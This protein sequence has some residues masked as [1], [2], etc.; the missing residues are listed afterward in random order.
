MIDSTTKEL[1]L[2]HSFTNSFQRT[3]NGVARL[4]LNSLGVLFTKPRLE[5][6]KNSLDTTRR[7]SIR[8]NSQWWSIVNEALDH[9]DLRI[10]QIVAWVAAGDDIILA[11]YVPVGNKPTPKLRRVIKNLSLIHI[12]EPTRPY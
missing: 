3:V 5:G 2:P 10:D 7:R 8:F 12:S 9:H 11:D 4:D 6:D 1:G